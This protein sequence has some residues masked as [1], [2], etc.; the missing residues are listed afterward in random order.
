[1]KY[2]VIAFS[3][4]VSFFLS[5]EDMITFDVDK[6]F[7]QNSTVDLLQGSLIARSLQVIT[8]K[9]LVSVSPE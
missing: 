6:L 4:L 3:I 8:G 9:D 2:I 7:V 1:M 5:A